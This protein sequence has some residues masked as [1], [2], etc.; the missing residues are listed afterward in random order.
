MHENITLGIVP[1]SQQLGGCRWLAAVV[2]VGSLLLVL[3]VYPL[4]ACSRGKER[5]SL[6][7]FQ[8]TGVLPSPRSIARGHKAF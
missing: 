3:L 1:T 6:Q 2:I 7:V 4:E 5:Y 8:D